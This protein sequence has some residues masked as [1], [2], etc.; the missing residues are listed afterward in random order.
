MDQVLERW[1]EPTL[2]SALEALPVVVLTGPRQ[3]GKTTLARASHPDRTFLTL[4]DIG[5]L[6]QAQQEP[7]T[8]LAARPL[9]VD[10]VQRAPELLLA[11]KREVDRRRTPGDFL[12]TGSA[13]LALLDRVADSLA[14]RALYLELP[15]FCPTEWTGRPGGLDPLDQLFAPG[16]DPR[17]WPV[18]SGDWQPWLLRGG[19]P[20]ALMAGSDEAR[21]LWFAGYVQTYLERDLRQ[22]SNVSSLP[23]FQRL[24][25]IAANRTGRL[26]N[27]SE[28]AR[29][30]ALAQPTAHR[31][32]N[33]VETGHLL[34]RVPTYAT[35]PTTALVKSPKLF[36][37]DAGLAAFLAGIRSQDQ[38][39]ERADIGFWFEQA[40]FQTCQTWRSID[41]VGRRIH[42]WRDRSGREVDLIIEKD[43]QLVALE[44]KSGSNTAISDAS[45][46][47]A[48]KESLPRRNPLR[49]GVV[50][51]GGPARSLGADVWALPWGWMFPP[52]PPTA[53]VPR[54]KPPAA[55]TNR[56]G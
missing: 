38:L 52:V 47:A 39:A 19:F 20:P 33:L 49:R 22:L 54:V 23:D 55:G 18:G 12:L 51:H 32:L 30:A 43:G 10:E 3:S 34:T 53:T 37:T 35:N 41:P 25:A 44:L 21:R 48:L 16:F 14:G 42:F 27:Q 15:P 36:W 46:I 17:H 24:M 11:V 31:Y 1:L 28:I 45:G 50:L 2:H 26:L 29:D 9:T 56:R 13:N 4:D 8:L 40:I 6:R 5:T 7:E